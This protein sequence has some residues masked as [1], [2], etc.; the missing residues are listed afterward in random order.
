VED[1]WK[2]RYTGGSEKRLYK[3]Q[4]F[5]IIFRRCQANLRVFID[6]YMIYME[7]ASNIESIRLLNS[8]TQ[9]AF[10]FNS[11][12]RS[13]LEVVVRTGRLRTTRL[14]WRESKTHNEFIPRCEATGPSQYFIAPQITQYAVFQADG[15]RQI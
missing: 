13:Q 7:S 2:K 15:T 10:V 14:L 9:A 11:F 12:D 4:E 1:K 3:T 6:I 5:L 8:F